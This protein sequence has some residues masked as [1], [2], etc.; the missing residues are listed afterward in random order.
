MHLLIMLELVQ[1]VYIDWISMEFMRK[2]MD[3]NFFGHVAMTK[4]FL[5]LLIS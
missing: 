3:V 5:P 2:M 1:V 4:K